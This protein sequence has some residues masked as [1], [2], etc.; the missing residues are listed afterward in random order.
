M[1][2]SKF[3]PGIGQI[4]L[5]FDVLNLI[6]KISGGNAEVFDI[7]T[8]AQKLYDKITNTTSDL[9]DLDALKKGVLKI[10]M[11]DGTVYARPLSKELRLAH[12]II[13]EPQGQISGG[14]KDDVLFGGSGNDT[15]QGG[16]GDDILIGKTG[17]DTYIFGE[18]FGNDTIIEE[19]SDKNV[20]KFTNGISKDNLLFKKL[21]NDLVILQNTNSINN[22][23]VFY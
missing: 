15:L 6:T 21:N 16:Y 1:A 20:I 4:S 7:R 13:G 17:N 19:N 8:K 2:V 9:P 5:A 22:K 11:P 23:T 3:I 10:T 18:D 12:G 14:N